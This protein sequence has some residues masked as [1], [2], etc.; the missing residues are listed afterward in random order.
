[1]LNATCIVL[2][3]MTNKRSLEVSVDF[4]TDSWK[5]M[6]AHVQIPVQLLTKTEGLKM[7]SRHEYLLKILQVVLKQ[8]QVLK[9][10]VMD[11][12]QVGISEI[13]CITA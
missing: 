10:L 1:M 5:I 7:R 4:S 13:P 2:L 6:D 12:R 9:S 11:F 8:S 3:F